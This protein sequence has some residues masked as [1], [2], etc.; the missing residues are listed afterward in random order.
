MLPATILQPTQN[1]RYISQALQR[2]HPDRTVVFTS[3]SE[4]NDNMVAINEKM[5]F[6]PVELFVE[7][8]R[9]LDG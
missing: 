2:A 5:G 1:R 8:Q 6:R 3:N 4:L 9:K 7:F